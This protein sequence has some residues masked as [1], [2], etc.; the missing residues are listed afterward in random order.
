MI[1]N[2]YLLGLF[3]TGVGTGSAY[4]G[5]VTPA[6]T[7]AKKQPTAPWAAGGTLPEASTVVR[8][9]L[10]GRRLINEGAERLD[11]PGA[12]ADYRKLFALYKGLDALTALAARADQRGVGTSE[13]ALIRQRFAAGLAEVSDYLRGSEFD[14]IRMV[15][16]VSS[17]TAKTT[18]SV[19]RD[20]TRIVTKP[21]HD[22]SLFSSVEAFEGDVRFD[23]TVHTLGGD[24][25]VSIDLADMGAQ[26]RTLDDV[27]AHI[28]GKLTD[29]GVNTRF[30]RQKVNGEPRTIKVGE[31]TITLP[32]Q[33]D[34]WALV[35]QG[36]STETVRF[37]APLLSDAVYVVQGV[38]ADS[39]NQLLKFQS[40]GGDSPEPV[41]VGSQTGWVTGRAAQTA[42]PKGVET[43]RASAV[44]AD[45]SL[46]MVADVEPA[47][48]EQPIKGERDVAL[49]KFDPSGRLVAT[50]MLG[51]AAQASGYA[52][53]IAAD[54]RV[55]VAGSV[56][57]AL[58]PGAKLADADLADSFVTVFD[59]AAEEL[60][61]ARRGAKAA[62]EATAV[63]FGDDGK[64]YVAGR[65]KSGMPGASGLGGWDGYLQ[66]F[67]ATQTHSLAP[68]VPVQTSISQ[69]GTASDDSV[70]A[71]TIEGGS[72]YTAGVEAGRVVVRQYATGGGAP[73]LSATRDLGPA[74]GDVT[75]IAVADGRVVLTGTTKN[76]AL[77]IATVNTA[78]SGGV[79]SYVA[80]LEAD[81]T[82]SAGDRLTYLGG[83]GDDGAS[84]MKV[85]DGKVWITGLAE[86][87]LGAKEDDPRQGYLSRI[88]PLTGA[89]EWTR[90]WVGAGQQ[91]RPLTLA[92]ATDGASVLDR[93]GLPQGEVSAGDSRIL[94][95]VT[96]LRPGDRF[97]VT[98]ADGSRARVVTIDA[99]DT[100]QTLAKKIEQ[101]S[102]GQLKASVVMDP[103]TGPIGSDLMS[104]RLQRLSIVPRDG[105]E[106]AF[107]SSGEPGRDALAA[108]GLSPGIVAPKAVPGDVRTFAVALPLSLSLAGSEKIKATKAVLES[109]MMTVRSAYRGLASGPIKPTVTGTAP[110]YLSAQLAN[111]QAALARLGG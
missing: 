89:V 95:N 47:A 24:K 4:S 103:S 94:T 53:A 88:D 27:I 38:G 28:N 14:G 6:T 80:V 20:I 78:H 43:V 12:S 69:F 75:G 102:F 66:G 92:V 96:A 7:T 25:T 30:S 31:K 36:T 1:N 19:P 81:L 10:A 13:A 9:V 56:T 3:G 83:A 106:G 104:G 107:L 79:D 63:S 84:D 34:Q 40:D 108:L 59:G 85:H 8:S 58:E 62:D 100:L 44:G 33:A 18:A 97:T 93:L 82:A 41:E 64:V 55:A 71:M 60:W 51:A 74:S 110:A 39:A 2:S 90:T 68:L 35:M 50:R 73:V 99:K 101:A 17:T 26:T 23:I 72:I 67:T 65:S 57:G 91:A 52:I 54:G 45:G 22:G 76:P 37:D 11:L 15:Q 16:G 32:A 111:Y 86:R 46:W 61:T 48:G 70:K 42:L 109:A 105:R 5:S 21:V 49:M 77:D 98:P 29:A 87:P